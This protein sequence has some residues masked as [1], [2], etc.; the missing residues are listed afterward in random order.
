ML[1]KFFL[2]NLLLSLPMN[3]CFASASSPFTS[4]AS[5]ATSSPSALLTKA[6]EFMSLMVAK[7]DDTKATDE[8][9]QQM[10]DGCITCGIVDRLCRANPRRYEVRQRL[11]EH[12]RLHVLLA[13]A[14]YMIG[15]NNYSKD[16]ELTEGII[17]SGIMLVKNFKEEF[18]SICKLMSNDGKIYDYK[19]K[20]EDVIKRASK[21]LRFDQFTKSDVH[22]DIPGGTI[23]P[24]D[25]PKNGYGR[26]VTIQNDFLQLLSETPVLSENESAPEVAYIAKLKHLEPL[27][28]NDPES[29]YIR[30]AYMNIAEMGSRNAEIARYNVPNTVHHRIL[31]DF[32]NRDYTRFLNYQKYV[33]SG[34]SVLGIAAQER[35]NLNQASGSGGAYYGNTHNMTSSSNSTSSND[36]S[37]PPPPPP[38]NSYGTNKTSANTAHKRGSSSNSGQTS[39]SNKNSSSGG[40]VVRPN[41]DLST[42]GSVRL[43]PTSHSPS[44]SGNTVNSGVPSNP[45]NHLY[46]QGKTV[47]ERK[48]SEQ[49][50]NSAAS[51]D[52]LNFDSFEDMTKLGNYADFEDVQQLVSKIR[53]DYDLE[54]DFSITWSDVNP[55]KI[56]TEDKDSENVKKYKTKW[57]ENRQKAIE[58][59]ARPSAS[60]KVP[61]LKLLS[62]STSSTVTNTPS[63]SASTTDTSSDSASTTDTSNSSASEV[64]ARDEGPVNENQAKEIFEK[65][66]SWFYDKS[67]TYTRT[68][69]QPKKAELETL[70]KRLTLGLEK[71]MIGAVKVSKLHVIINQLIDRMD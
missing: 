29:A 51:K 40:T 7:I 61:K 25:I 41:L 66:N 4:S 31:T 49:M 10:I 33:S 62:R 18:A 64:A 52:P 27:E 47:K 56:T 68:E 50:E 39:N 14:F 23:I 13:H 1:K 43:R 54:N 30:Q 12:K 36:S 19:D 22:V 21:P 42:I 3:D 37:V 70:K 32:W 6:S 45:L 60:G 28:S 48:L 2:L 5:S 65:I 17:S 71:G 63:N 59:K 20:L 24:F 26:L 34:H 16:A 57:N 69:I 53:V 35:V 58:L 8:Q 38:P 46:A 67:K 55:F 15:Y 9:I 44:P 11:P